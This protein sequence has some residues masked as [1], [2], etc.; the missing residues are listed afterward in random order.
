VTIFYLAT[1]QDCE[2]VL[3]MPFYDEEE[4][5]TWSRRHREA[6]NHVVVHEEEIR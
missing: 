1:C 2:P 5:Y 3:P 6:T 4:R